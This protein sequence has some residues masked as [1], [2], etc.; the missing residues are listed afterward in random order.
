MTDTRGPLTQEIAFQALTD[1]FR[2]KSLVFFGTGMSCAI[3]E[4][5]GM[6]A[7]AGV[8]RAQ[9]PASSLT[10]DQRQEWSMVED[11]LKKGGDLESAMNKVLDQSLVE[12]ITTVAGNF[13]S[14]IDCENSLKIADGRVE[15]PA[16][17]LLKVL[18][19]TLPEGDPILNVI[20]P[21]YD[22]IMEYACDHAGIPYINGFTGGIER[23]IDWNAAERCMWIP[24]QTVVGHHIQRPFTRRKH[25]RLY[26]V[27]GSLNYFTY[28]NKVIENNAWILNPP[29][30]A[31]RIMITPGVSKYERLQ[32]Y[33]Q[34][35]LR[36]A[37]SAIDR[38]SRFLFLGYGFNDNHLEQY[39]RR[40]LI[41]QASHGLIITR[42]CNPRIMDILRMAPNLWLVCRSIGGSDR[43]TGIYNT[44]Y[45]GWLNLNDTILW[46]VDEFKKQIIGG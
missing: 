44:Q 30:F 10:K 19:D 28:N 14:L 46:D 27:H 35:L 29:P 21:N 43:Q 24:T 23:K 5:F 22:L 13:V 15:W 33:R 3:D 40:K 16:A 17:K 34:E 39:I 25:V 37:D 38:E 7:L 8:L 12:Q 42:D 32:M 20:T 45:S 6:A 4:R 2:E 11:I 9:L 31:R 26:K 36:Q 18:V 1:F 41:D